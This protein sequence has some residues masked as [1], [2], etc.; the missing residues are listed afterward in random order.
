MPEQTQ[1]PERIDLKD[2]VLLTYL[3]LWAERLCVGFWPLWSAL[4]AF[5]AFIFLGLH[6]VLPL[7]LVWGFFV[8]S[9]FGACFGTWYAWRRFARPSRE[10]ALERIDASLVGRPIRAVRDRQAT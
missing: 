6:E 10:E 5:L 3:G 2:Q 8:F 9:A 4:I 7:E 1:K